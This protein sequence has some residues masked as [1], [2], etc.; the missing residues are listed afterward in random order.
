MEIG[1]SWVANQWRIMGKQANITLRSLGFLLSKICDL[2]RL[3]VLIT[4]QKSRKCA[5]N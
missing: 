5:Q 2:L 1:G 4:F 3:L